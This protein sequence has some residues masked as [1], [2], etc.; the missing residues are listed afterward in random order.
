MVKKGQI[1]GGRGVL[2]VILGG[3]RGVKIGVKRGAQ[4]QGGHF[5]GHLGGQ[6]VIYKRALIKP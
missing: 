5:R 6:K 2:G 4:E 1:G 3:G